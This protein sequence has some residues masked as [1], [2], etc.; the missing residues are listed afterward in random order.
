MLRPDGWKARGP[1]QD[2]ARKVVSPP[3][4]GRVEKSLARKTQ[5]STEKEARKIEEATRGG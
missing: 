4:K 3:E 5:A 2:V 1:V